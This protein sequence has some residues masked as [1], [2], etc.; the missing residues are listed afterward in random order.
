MA[1]LRTSSPLINAVEGDVFTLLA[2]TDEGQEH[3]ELA[4]A[5]TICAFLATRD[6]KVEDLLLFLPAKPTAGQHIFD[7]TQPN[8]HPGAFSGIDDGVEGIDIAIGD[9]G[10]RQEVL[11]EILASILLWGGHGP[12]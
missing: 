5:H 8:A 2:E 12:G 7:S 6:D 4:P 3:I 9:I 1:G 10:C 11:D